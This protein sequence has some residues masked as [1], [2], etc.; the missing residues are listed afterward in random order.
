MLG[1]A[2]RALIEAARVDGKD[3]Y[4]RILA[5]FGQVERRTP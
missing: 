1:L 3:F 5:D 4:Q 2:V